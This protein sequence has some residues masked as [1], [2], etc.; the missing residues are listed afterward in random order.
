M[1]RINF[2]FNEKRIE[3]LEF[4]FHF[5]SSKMNELLISQYCFSYKMTRINFAGPRGITVILLSV[6]IVLY[7][8]AF[9]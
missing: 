7:I 5:Q 6:Y 9:N 4:K 3:H 1:T 8:Y 2:N